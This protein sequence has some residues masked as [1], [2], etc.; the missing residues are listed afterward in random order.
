MIIN[1][2]GCEEYFVIGHALTHALS[3]LGHELGHDL[4]N[5]VMVYSTGRAHR[6][7]TIVGFLHAGVV[8]MNTYTVNQQECKHTPTVVILLRTYLYL[9]LLRPNRLK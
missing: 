1:K 5:V 4:H 8:S 7:I 6:A 9:A 3:P 2:L